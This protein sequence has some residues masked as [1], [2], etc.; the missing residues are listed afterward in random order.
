MFKPI[1]SRSFCNV[2]DTSMLNN[3]LIPLYSVSDANTLES[4]C[5]K[6][7]L[8]RAVNSTY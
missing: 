4:G 1:F 8:Y 2:V 6:T 5:L 7:R 3:L